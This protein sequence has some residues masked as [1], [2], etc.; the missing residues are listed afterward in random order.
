MRLLD[1]YVL[2]NFLVPFVYSTIGFLA[3][4]LVFDLSDNGHDFIEAHVKLTTLAY[5][6]L[7]QFP[8][9]LVLS[10][11]V[12]LLLALLYSL[13]RMSRSNEIISMLTAGQSVT[14]VMRPLFFCGVVTALFSLALNYSMA[15][16]SDVMRKA[17]MDLIT[18]GRDRSDTL[19]QQLYY[20]KAGTGACGLSRPSSARRIRSKASIFASGIPTGT[21]SRNC[22]R[23]TRFT[24]RSITPGHFTAAR[25]SPST[26]RATRSV[27]TTR[28]CV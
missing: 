24:I 4:W 22:T 20:N 26:S 6:Y 17:L 15:P 27:R 8:Q 18:K 19:E 12:G 11:P 9:I 3:I 23:I 25:R 16:H 14:R 2:Q 21:S 5:F 7:T 28:G 10:L 1:R 13:S